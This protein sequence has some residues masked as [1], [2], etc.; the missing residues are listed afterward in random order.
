MGIK[1]STGILVAAKFPLEQDYLE[2]VIFNAELVFLKDQ[3]LLFNFETRK[4]DCF[5]WT[6]AELQWADHFSVL[7]V[8]IV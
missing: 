2:G 8:L 1:K 4:F 3:L 5:L 6:F 7:S